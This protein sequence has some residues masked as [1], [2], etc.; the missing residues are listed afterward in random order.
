MVEIG[1]GSVGGGGVGKG[2]W[3]DGGGVLKE[4]RER[5]RERRREL[6]GEGNQ[7]LYKFRF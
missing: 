7:S 6:E 1:V 2:D 3:M 5:G 4:R